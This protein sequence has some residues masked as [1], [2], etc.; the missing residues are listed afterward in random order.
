MFQKKWRVK[1]EAFPKSVGDLW[2]MFWHHPW[3][4]RASQKIKKVDQTSK[5]KNASQKLQ[6]HI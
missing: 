5:K 2:A 4:L 1:N 6:N 3:C